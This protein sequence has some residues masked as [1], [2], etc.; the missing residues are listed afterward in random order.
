MIFK[1]VTR[2]REITRVLRGL[3]PDE[4]VRQ[5]T[6]A[7][8][9]Q[10]VRVSSP[11]SLLEGLRACQSI[12][13]NSCELRKF[14]SVGRVKVDYVRPA[15]VYRAEVLEGQCKPL[16]IHLVFL[17]STCRCI[18]MLLL[19]SLFLPCRKQIILYAMRNV[20]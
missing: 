12:A 11:L 7:I 2:V 18:D 14:Q 4:V 10:I 3:S 9:E 6:I 1:F 17:G 15:S 13:S 8:N 16:L 19:P 20:V 5:R